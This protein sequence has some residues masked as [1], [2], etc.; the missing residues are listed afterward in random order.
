MV[1]TDHV[2][3]KLEWRMYAEIK[4]DLQVVSTPTTRHDLLL[5]II[6][7]YHL[8]FIVKLKI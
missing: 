6:Y 8:N 1:F 3:V 4:D 5:F 2:L 7:I